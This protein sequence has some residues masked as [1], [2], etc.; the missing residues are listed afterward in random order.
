MAGEE[1]QVSAPD[2]GLAPAH[3]VSILG[4]RGRPGGTEPLCLLS[5]GSDGKWV[6]AHGSW[7]GSL[8]SL[9]PF[10]LLTASA[11]QKTLPLCIPRPSLISSSEKCLVCPSPQSFSSLA[12]APGTTKFW[13]WPRKWCSHVLGN[14]EVKGHYQGLRVCARVCM[15]ACAWVCACTCVHVYVH[16]HIHAYMHVCM[17]VCASAYTYVS[18]CYIS[19]PCIFH[20]LAWSLHLSLKFLISILTQISPPLLPLDRVL[21][22]ND[23]LLLA[24]LVP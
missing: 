21:P 18:P 7:A 22:G 15:H 12:S 6:R 1:T 14:W 19:I 23:F 8:A 16:V 11:A 24:P 9:C 10:S 3:Q 5:G 4:C 2:P 13:H 17:H 20:L